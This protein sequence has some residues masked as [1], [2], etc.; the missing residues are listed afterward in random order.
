MRP[1]R[2]ALSILACV[3]SITRATLAASE[4]EAGSCPPQ[5][6]VRLVAEAGSLAS[7]YNRG[8]FG[9]DGTDL[10]LRKAAGQ[11][12]LLTYTRWSAELTIAERHTI[13]LLPAALVHWHD[14][15]GFGHS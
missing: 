15:A 9:R 7:L 6:Q 13:I 10:D 14:D 1:Y 5:Y 8:Q 3:S 4:T 12:N 11:D 2:V